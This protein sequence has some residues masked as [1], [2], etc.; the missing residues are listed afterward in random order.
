MMNNITYKNKIPHWGK[1]AT[2]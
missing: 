2:T 1:R